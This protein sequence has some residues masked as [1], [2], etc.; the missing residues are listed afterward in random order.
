MNFKMTMNKNTLLDPD[1]IIDSFDQFGFK[2]TIIE[3]IKKIGFRKPS[4]IQSK[5]IPHILQ[6]KDI[7]GQS[8]TGTGKT[9]AFGLPIIQNLSSE[10]KIDCL[11]VVPTRELA[12]QVSGELYKLGEGEKVTVLSIYGGQSYQRQID[13]INRKP[14]IV[15]A[16][17][18][19]LLDLF[20]KGV[21][22]NF[23]PHTVVL[24]EADEMLD[25]GFLEDIET[26]FKYV[27]DLKQTV[28]FSATMPQPIKKLAKSILNNP[29]LVS[30]VDEN[31]KNVNINI[32]EFYVI[33]KDHERGDAVVRLIDS[34]KIEKIIV[35][36]R[37]K[38][39]VDKLNTYLVSNGYPSGCLHGDMD[40]KQRKKT[41]DSFQ[42]EKISILVATDVASRGL[43]IKKVSHVF[44]YHIPFEKESY[45]HR[46]GRTGRAG[47]KGVAITLVT[48]KEYGKLCRFK[49]MIGGDILPC[50][51]PNSKDLQHSVIEKSLAE[52]REIEIHSLSSEY[53]EKWKGLESLENISL[54]LLSH[55]L[56]NESVLGP[57][58][59]GFSA[60]EIESIVQNEKKN[61]EKGGRSQNNRRRQRER[62]RRP[63]GSN[64]K[65]SRNLDRKSFR[66]SKIQKSTSSRDKRR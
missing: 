17:P 28:L 46:I 38:N 63:S 5:A 64:F 3:T 4:P 45:I 53:L 23:S 40:Q 41:I 48:P 59:I 11:V 49:K 34:E 16:T 8:H 56:A 15:V 52:I 13:G 60:K 26:I 1:I 14:N 29:I 18:G 27:P 66:S 43:D 35:F 9:A 55:I 65:S 58:Q 6:G 7:I 36:C 33:I 22:K 42:Q 57:S 61:L 10:K 37:T 19:R 24:D 21:F 39:E 44:N 12:T 54:K 31:S 51:I 32:Q 62:D 25:M 2:K 47:E 50:F 30:V 20:K